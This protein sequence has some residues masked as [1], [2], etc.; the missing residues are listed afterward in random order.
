MRGA[1]PPFPQYASMA[2]CSVKKKYRDNFNF[3]LPY[4]AVRKRS[5]YIAVALYT[6]GTAHQSEQGR[7]N[8]DHW[9]K[10]VYT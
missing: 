4:Q 1:I 10:G 5:T 7:R 3:T 9:T 2:W 6:A 8:G